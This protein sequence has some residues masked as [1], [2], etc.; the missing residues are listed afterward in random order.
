MPREDLIDALT[1]FEGNQ[2]PSAFATNR[3]QE[4][5]KALAFVHRLYEM[6]AEQVLVTGIY[7]EAWRTQ[8]EGGPYADTLVV[9]MPDDPVKRQAL[10]DLCAEET[11]GEDPEEIKQDNGQQSITFWWD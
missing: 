7:D 2:N 9:L 10:L 4:T 8:Q 6:G 11:E 5:E 3:F 1:W